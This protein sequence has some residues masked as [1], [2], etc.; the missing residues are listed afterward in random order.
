M[1]AL[2]TAFAMRPSAVL[3]VDGAA[4]QNS[5][6]GF[7]G[8]STPCRTLDDGAWSCGH[9]DRQMSGDVSYRVKVNGLGCW[10]ATRDG[11]AGEG[12]SPKHLS[13]CVTILDFLL[14]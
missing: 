9:P 7:F 14:D 8:P 3:G 11:Y 6:G 1:F 4:L 13:G 5:V 12:G 10:Q 2:L